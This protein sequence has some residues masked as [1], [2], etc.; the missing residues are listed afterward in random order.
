[1]SLR[2]CPSTDPLVRFATF[3]HDVGKAF[4]FKKLETGVITFYNHELV[5]TRIA[6]NISKRLRF[7]NYEADK[8]W[9]LVRYHQFTTD[10][11]QTDSAIRRFIRNVT[12]ELVF[13]MLDLRTGD[14]L[15]GGAS[16]TSWR[17]EDFKVRLIEVQK[18]PFSVTDLKI[19]GNDVMKI[20][21]IK[22]G[23]KVGE[24]LGKLYNEVVEKKLDNERESLFKKIQEYSVIE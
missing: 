16:E 9:R 2:F 10:E 15:G 14:R 22:S 18:Q 5:S 19:N 17:F 7:S 3:I 20:L 24:I 13:D 1:M 4:T 12:P 11:R 8:F 6:K 23:P 21:K